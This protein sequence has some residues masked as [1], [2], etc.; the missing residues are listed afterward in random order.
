MSLGKMQSGTEWGISESLNI[1]PGKRQRWNSL[2]VAF[3]SQ[4]TAPV[5]SKGQR[6]D[7]LSGIQSQQILLESSEETLSQSF[8]LLQWG[9]SCQVP[10]CSLF[11]YLEKNDGHN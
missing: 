11:C 9:N 7:G 1:S 6:G 8:P 2:A 4:L 5:L 10:R 3:S